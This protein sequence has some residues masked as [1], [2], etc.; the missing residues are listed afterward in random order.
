MLAQD[1][2]A[3]VRGS[4][5]QRLG[6]IAQSLHNANDC[7]TLLLPCLI[8]LCKDDDVGVR[9]AILNTVAICLPHFSKGK[10]TVEL[11]LK[12]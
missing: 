9:E 11:R 4:I 1:P 2:N 7:G 6:F 10:L 3:N 8:E 12:G 5:A